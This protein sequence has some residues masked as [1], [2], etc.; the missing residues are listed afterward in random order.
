M[1]VVVNRNMQVAWD[2]FSVLYCSGRVDHLSQLYAIPK[3]SVPKEIEA[4]YQRICRYIWKHQGPLR[5]FFLPGR[6]GGTVLSGYVR[7]LFFQGQVCF[8]DI[9]APLMSHSHEDLCAQILY[10]LDLDNDFSL[11]FYRELCRQP[12]MLASYFAGAGSF[13]QQMQREFYHI[14]R[15]GNKLFRELFRFLGKVYRLV[16]GESERFQEAM[17]RLEEELRE[18][19][20]REGPD[21]L[22][23]FEREQGK[24]KLM[25]AYRKVETLT[26]TPT[27]Y[28]LYEVQMIF[29]Y[30]RCVMQVGMEY[31]EGLMA[32]RVY[33]QGL[34]G[35]LMPFAQR[36]RLRVVRKLSQ[37]A[38]ASLED[39]SLCLEMDKAT[40]L[41]HL[42]VLRALGFVQ[43]RHR[44]GT[45]CYFLNR[46]MIRESVA[47]L[48][49]YAREDDLPASS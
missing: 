42:Y 31:E 9:M 1:D 8:E 21:F 10:K 5:L 25:D 24:E 27:I 13:T 40:L 33:R 2:F 35:R 17:V 38:W 18:R 12:E 49:W 48:Q 16:E 22:L 47:L 4:S 29:S 7:T 6:N 34:Y 28:M 3:R 32:L 30:Q 39:L 14:L 41:H 46:P 19:V 20:S 43:R 15:L 44:R 36:S 45:S 11:A 23:W 37:V 26:I